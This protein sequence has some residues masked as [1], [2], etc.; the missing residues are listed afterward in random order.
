VTDLIFAP[1]DQ[2]ETRT[3]A[4]LR[5]A[6]ADEASAGAATRAMLHASRLGMVSGL[7]RTMPAPQHRQRWRETHLTKS[8]AHCSWDRARNRHGCVRRP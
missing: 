1:L 6:G 7:P 2:L 8:A 4:A 3:V 5:N